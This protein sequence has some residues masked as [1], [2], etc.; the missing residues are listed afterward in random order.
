MTARS[1]LYD[2]KLRLVGQT[3]AKIVEFAAADYLEHIGEHVEAH[4]YLK[5]P[6]YRPM[7]WPEG[8]HRVPA[9]PPERRQLHQHAAGAGRD[10]QVKGLNGGRPVEGTLWF[11]RA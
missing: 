1:D 6:F 11:L 8:V 3:G 2:G 4:T 5:S 9:G 7:G 10:A